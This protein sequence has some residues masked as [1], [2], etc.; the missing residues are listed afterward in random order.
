MSGFLGALGRA[1]APGGGAPVHPCAGGA[2]VHPA[3]DGAQ[4]ACGEPPGCGVEPAASAG[5]IPSMRRDVASQPI[6]SPPEFGGG[7]IP[8][9]DDPG[10]DCAAGGAGSP[11]GGR[12]ASGGCGPDEATMTVRPPGPTSSGSGRRPRD[13]S[14]LSRSRIARSVPPSCWPRSQSSRS[15]WHA[16]LRASAGHRSGLVAA[17]VCRTDCAERWSAAAA[18]WGSWTVCTG[19]LA[20]IGGADAAGAWA[21]GVPQEP[22]KRLPGE[23]AKPQ[24]LQEPANLTGDPPGPTWTG[25][26]GAPH[27]PQKCSPARTAAPQ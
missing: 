16:G 15:A 19:C 23:I 14:L 27:D 6:C 18:P 26:F 2:S 17:I 5:R 24:V 12:W 22:Q 3:A 25:A 11:R 7:Q 8:D 20:T 10:G 4:P 9:T 1:A 21:I 13:A